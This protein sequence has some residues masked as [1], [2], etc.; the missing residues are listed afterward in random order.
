MWHQLRTKHL[1]QNTYPITE[2]N[3]L[4]NA[5][6]HIERTDLPEN[7]YR[8]ATPNKTTGFVHSY[9]DGA[10][11][12]KD[13]QYQGKILPLSMGQILKSNFA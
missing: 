13:R 5:G 4:P 7:K 1:P 6:H 12:D 2:K 10:A 3:I 8:D 11:S 9:P